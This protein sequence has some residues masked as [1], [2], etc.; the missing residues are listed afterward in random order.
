MTP[1]TTAVPT[2]AAKPLGLG[3]GLDTLD[4]LLTGTTIQHP[5]L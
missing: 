1:G 5:S 3:P 4:P 2:V